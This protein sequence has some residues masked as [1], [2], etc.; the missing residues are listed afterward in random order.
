MSSELAA[1]RSRWLRVP[2]KCK[3]TPLIPGFAKEGD[4]G[5]G[6]LGKEGQ[7]HR[8]RGGH[9]RVSG[10]SWAWER[11]KQSK[12]LT[13]DGT[14]LSF[15][16]LLLLLLAALLPHLARHVLPVLPGESAHSSQMLLHGFVPRPAPLS[17][18]RDG[19]LL[20]CPGLPGP[21][22]CPGAAGAPQ[23]QQQHQDTAAEPAEGGE[24]VL[25]HGRDAG[26]AMESPGG[27][28]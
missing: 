8:S 9:S 21:G 13:C 15:F 23:E 27:P 18:L 4:S 10:P 19:S 5:A 20:L 6:T 16:S 25:A 28:S 11:K 14:G 24:P 22:R 1:A 26:Q 7:H 2:K 12:A 17:P 3:N